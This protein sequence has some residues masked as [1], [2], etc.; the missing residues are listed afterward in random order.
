MFLTTLRATKTNQFW[1]SLRKSYYAIIIWAYLANLITLC[2]ESY[3]FYLYISI[4]WIFIVDLKF[5]PIS[6]LIKYPHTKVL[7][8]HLMT[9]TYR[10]ELRSSLLVFQLL[11]LWMS[12][13]GSSSD[14]L[15][16]KYL[17]SSMEVSR[18]ASFI[19]SRA[20]SCVQ[21]VRSIPEGSKC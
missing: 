13:V 11:K 16:P 5:P 14:L 20:W 4:G 10:I 7:I 1:A 3:I 9:S 6:H 8:W 12:G 19:R 18:G 2:H 15:R 17:D 21:F